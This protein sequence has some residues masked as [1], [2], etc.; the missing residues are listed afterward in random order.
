MVE[1]ND[2]TLTDN[3]ASIK[4][5]LILIRYSTEMVMAHPYGHYT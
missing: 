4:I 5:N 2:E 1:N 3:I